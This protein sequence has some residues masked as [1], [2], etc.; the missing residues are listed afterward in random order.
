MWGVD[1]RKMWKGPSP[2]VRASAPPA[3]ASRRVHAPS[4]AGRRGSGRRGE[5]RGGTGRDG[6]GRGGTERGGAERSGAGNRGQGSPPRRDHPPHP[7]PCPSLHLPSP[8]HYPIPSGTLSVLELRAGALHWP[9]CQG[10]PPLSS[11]G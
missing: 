4:G 7:H 3:S 6:A 1:R 11:R 5:V 9:Q 8:I 2:T 10:R